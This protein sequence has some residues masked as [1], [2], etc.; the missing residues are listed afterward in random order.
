MQE[1]LLNQ[2]LNYSILFL[3][4]VVAGQI[5]WFAINIRKSKLLQ[6]SIFTIGLA[7]AVSIG[8]IFKAPGFIVNPEVEVFWLFIN[9]LIGLFVLYS[10]FKNSVIPSLILYISVVLSLIGNVT[11]FSGILEF[12][13]R[14]MPTILFFTICIYSGVGLIIYQFKVAKLQKMQKRLS[15]LAAG[16]VFTVV[17]FGAFDTYQ[18]VRDTAYTDVS[19]GWEGG[20]TEQQDELSN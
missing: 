16:L 18:L 19:E 12:G 5:I 4:A 1:L 20:V 9:A 3:N 17:C 6:Y 11:V 13:M 14:Y 15:Y 8:G 2:W 10:F 7:Y